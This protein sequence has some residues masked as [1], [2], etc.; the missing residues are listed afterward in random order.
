MTLARP[1]G[2][3]TTYYKVD[4][5]HPEAEGLAGDFNGELL[6]QERGGYAAHL[7]PAF[8]Q[9]QEGVAQRHSR[10]GHGDIVIEGLSMEG[11]RKV[12]AIFDSLKPEATRAE[13]ED[14]IIKNL[15]WVTWDRP[16][17]GR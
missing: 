12:T 2:E 3:P 5:T 14:A 16:L 15:D 7:A 6:G 17:S 1:S 8:H 10:E 9:P 11:W 4:K 13:I